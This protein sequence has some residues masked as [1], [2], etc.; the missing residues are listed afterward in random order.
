MIKITYTE[1][2]GSPSDFVSY[3]SIP[4]A[5]ILLCFRESAEV[6]RNV[7]VESVMVG[8][9]ICIGKSKPMKVAAIDPD[10]Q[11]DE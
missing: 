5:H 4:S 7:S 2:D 1:V 6:D 9:T 11:G 10:W 8:D 3:H